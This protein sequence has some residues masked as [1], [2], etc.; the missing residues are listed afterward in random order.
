MGD[1]QPEVGIESSHLSQQLGILRKAGVVTSRR[2]GS[3]VF[4][5]LT[6]HQIVE[7]LAVTKRILISALST[8]SEL[9]E[10]LRGAE[11]GP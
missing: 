4:Y 3:S 8:D 7:L 2:E 6:D 11:G 5:S 9:L 1:M 10:D